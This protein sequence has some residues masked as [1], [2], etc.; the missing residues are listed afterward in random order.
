MEENCQQIIREILTDLDLTFHEL[1]D[2][3]RPRFQIT[4]CKENIRRNIYFNIPKNKTFVFQLIFESGNR[5]RILRD[6]LASELRILFH[7]P[8]PI[9]GG[10]GLGA[11]YRRPR[12][13]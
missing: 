8:Y 11:L 6:R 2:H 10:R 12:S 9:G 3:G 5:D 1:N 4:A 7:A 13:L